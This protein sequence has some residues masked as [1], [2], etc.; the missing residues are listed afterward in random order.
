MELLLHA[1]APAVVLVEQPAGGRGGSLGP[2]DQG[3]EFFG[4]LHHGFL[5]Y[6]PNMD[7]PVVADNGEAGCRKS[8][9]DAFVFDLLGY[10]RFLLS[11]GIGRSLS[12]P[13]N[14]SYQS[15]A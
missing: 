12:R 8:H 14:E 1:A 2:P 3:R 10:Y 15:H 6:R 9:R 4:H 5:R 7:L 11:A 13:A